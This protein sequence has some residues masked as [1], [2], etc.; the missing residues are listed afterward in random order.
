[1]VINRQ[2]QCPASS[3]Y[4]LDVNFPK[5]MHYVGV[6]KTQFFNLE[7]DHHTYLINENDT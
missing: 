7:K 6:L 3:K 2:A 4:S 1:M 5:N